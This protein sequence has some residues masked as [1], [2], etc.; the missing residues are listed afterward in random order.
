MTRITRRSADLF[1]RAPQP[2]LKKAS[3]PPPRRQVNDTFEAAPKRP[4]PASFATV[5]DVVGLVPDGKVAKEG[6]VDAGV[7]KLKGGVSASSKTEA[8]GT[9]VLTVEVHGEA[10]ASANGGTG[11][12]SGSVKA[13]GSITVRLPPGCTEN[14]A[15]IDPLDPATWPVGT[16]VRVEG[17]VSGAAKGRVGREVT[18]ADIKA[19]LAAQVGVSG[20]AGLEVEIE[21]T[22]PTTVQVSVK[23]TTSVG[24]NGEVSASGTVEGVEV[25][26]T[27]KGEIQNTTT[28]ARTVEFDLATPAG[29]AAYEKF[30]AT[31]ELPPPGPGITKWTD[32]A[33]DSTTGSYEVSVT[34][35]VKVT[36]FG[37]EWTSTK[38]TTTS[39]DGSV[40][41]EERL[42]NDTDD[43]TIVIERT[44]RTDGT[45]DVKVRYEMTVTAENKA[46]LEEML[47]KAYGQAYELK[48]GQT[49]SVDMSLADLEKLN[50]QVD[51]YGWDS[52]LTSVTGYD[53]SMHDELDGGAELP[54]GTEVPNL[55]AEAITRMADDQKVRVPGAVKVTDQQGN[56]V[57]ALTAEQIV[58]KIQQQVDAMFGGQSSGGG[59]GG[60]GARGW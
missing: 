4:S 46:Q 49:V 11:G 37:N 51:A 35:G 16:K 42:R 21:K 54:N 10:S 43:A 2:S 18:V 38:T 33:T 47:R 12:V 36:L 14:P 57:P 60:G 19:K 56:E 29:K 6:G 45:E 50:E 53:R 9:K 25:G 52:F 3:Q 58:T 7:V 48:P 27:A 22:G 39:V 13:K 23:P 40:K 55:D 8:D 28:H 41:I 24:V 31:G 26:A 32:V 5:A 44:I 30:Q 15:N 34:L 20:S 1:Y 17:D 59:A